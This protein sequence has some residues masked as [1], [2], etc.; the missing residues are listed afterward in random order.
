MNN[1]ELNKI[2]CESNLETMKRMEDLS[3]D[4]ALTSPP[5]NVGDNKMV[6]TKYEGYTDK[7]DDYFENQ[8]NLINELLRV[9]KNHV[10][11]NIQMLGNNKVDFLNLLG[12]FKNKIK[13]IIIWQKNMIPH[14]EHGVLSSSFEFIIIFSNDRPEKKKFYDGNFRGNFGNVIKTLNSHSNPFAKKHKAIMPL[15]I[16]RMFMTKFGKAKD[17]WYDPYM[18]TGTTAIS[19][20]MEDRKYIGSEISKEYCKVI[21]DRIKPYLSQTKLF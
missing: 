11:Y 19:A 8:K 2:Y 13:D 5:Y 6:E 14:I 16:P 21:E 17:V 4:Y 10:F 3:I 1:L 18:G 9:T 20:I 12:H 15:D 7:L